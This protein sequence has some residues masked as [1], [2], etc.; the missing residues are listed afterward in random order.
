MR[1]ISSGSIAN[2]L[3][4]LSQNTNYVFVKFFRF[5]FFNL[6]CFLTR[7]IKDP[8]YV[9]HYNKVGHNYIRSSHGSLTWLEILSD[10]CKEF[11]P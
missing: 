7:N 2:A 10:G 11:L 5:I 8:V 6:F 4:N 9:S 3:A 1:H